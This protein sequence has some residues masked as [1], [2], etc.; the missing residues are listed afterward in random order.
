[1]CARA[2]RAA[3]WTVACMQTGSPD[4]HAPGTAPPRG[5]TLIE[6]IVVLAIV[7]LL[8]SIAL[9]R[10]AN[11]VEH[12]RETTLRS[13]LAAMREAI[14]RHSADRG[15]YPEDLQALV[16]AGYLNTVPEDPYTGRR[17]SWVLLSPPPDTELPGAVYDVRSGAAGRGRSGQLLADW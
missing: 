14:D 13:S 15:A 3:P 2:P 7:A 8:T 6:L 17:D 1:M 10:F 5:F 11:S 12:A 16:A 9:P 4:W